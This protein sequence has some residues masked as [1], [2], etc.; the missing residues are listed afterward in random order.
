MQGQ[1]GIKFLYERAR[2]KAEAI[3][4]RFTAVSCHSERNEVKR[5]ISPGENRCKSLHPRLISLRSAEFVSLFVLCVL[6][7]S[8]AAVAADSY[9]IDEVADAT[10]YGASIYDNVGIYMDGYGD[11]NGDGIDDFLVSTRQIIGQIVISGDNYGYIA[12]N[13]GYIL[14]GSSNF[15]NEIDLAYP[16][17]GT[18]VIRF[19]DLGGVKVA[20]GDFNGDGLCDAAF[21]NSSVPVNG[22]DAAGMVVVLYGG[23]D[24]P[25]DNDF[26]EL[27]GPGFMIPGHRLCNGLGYQMSRAGD[28]NGDG[29]MDLLITGGGRC[30]PGHEQEFFLIY[31][32]PDIPET[33]DLENLG[34]HGVRFVGDHFG[35]EVGWA[36]DT[37]GDGLDD[38]LLGCK[39]DVYD[40]LGHCYLVYGATDYP[41]E[42]KQA[43]MQIYG[44]DFVGEAI[45]DR[46]G[47][48]GRHHSG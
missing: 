30:Q 8:P 28:V 20:A 16:P 23:P 6:M 7:L 18:V 27:K 43:D 48:I 41:S 47:S 11:I 33:L 36:G 14:W 38:F 4:W 46:F 26:V 35:W 21:S 34:G 25:R 10:I 40:V 1:A 17:E 2:R 15:N 42:I 9:R 19:G 3:M 31:G 37:N 13:Y 24:M 39:G 32:G 29:Y 44:V 12:D 5:R 45:D 22:L